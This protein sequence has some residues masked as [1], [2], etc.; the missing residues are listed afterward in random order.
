MDMT[1]VDVT[2]VPECRVGD[3]A[4]LIGRQGHEAITANEVAEL[5]QTNAYE[6]LCGIGSRVP[7]VVIHGR[8]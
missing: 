4:V 3:E 1:M 6:I 7:R 5:A 8:D 2:D